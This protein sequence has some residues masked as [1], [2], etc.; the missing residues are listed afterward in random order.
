MDIEKLL[1]RLLQVGIV[2]AI[3]ADRR[4][5]RVK[6]LDVDMTSGWLYVLQHSGANLY[7]TPDGKHTHSIQDTYSGGGTASYALEHDHDK[8]YVTTW[9]PKIN[10]V[11]LAAFL[12]IADADGFV[13]GGI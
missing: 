6:F 11:V 7:I 9:M 1:L 13:L 5:A 8:S 2:T 10:D 12:P 3:D 4:M